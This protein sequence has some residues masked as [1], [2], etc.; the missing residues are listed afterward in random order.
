MVFLAL[1]YQLGRMK[2]IKISCY[3]LHYAEVRGQSC[4]MSMNEVSYKV[5]PKPIGFIKI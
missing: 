2:F 4:L 3:I 5:Y 1:A